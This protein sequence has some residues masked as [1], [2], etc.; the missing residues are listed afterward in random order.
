[1]KP[2]SLLCLACILA[3]CRIHAQVNVPAR[4]SLNPAVSPPQVKLSW[5]SIPGKTYEVWTTAALGE[6]GMTTN[7]PPLK[8]RSTITELT[9]LA[10]LPQ[11]FYRIREQAVPPGN[12]GA[13]TATTVAELEK[14][15][16]LTFTPAQRT[17]LAGYLTDQRATFEAMRKTRLLNSDPPSLVFNPI[18]AGFVLETTQHP[19]SWS[20]PRNTAVPSNRRELAF[21]SVRDLGE[22]IRTRQITSTEL[23]QLFLER[24]KRYDS[25]LHCVINLTAE[26]A[27]EQAARADEELAAGKYRGPLHGI[28]Y[29]IKDL[30]SARK[31][32][33]TWGAAP[34]KD[35]VIDEDATVVKRLEL[36]GAVLIA[37]LSTGELA[38]NDVWFGGMTRNPWNPTQGSSGSS[39]G[40]ASATAAGLVAFSIGSETLGS[41]VSP[42]T[43]CR[44]TGLRP[45]FGR[46]SRA[47]AM[48]LSWSMDKV[49]PICR[50]VEDCALVLEAIRGAD[51]ID[52]A[53]INAPFNY[54]PKMEVTKLRVGYRSGFVSTTTVNRLAGIVGQPQLSK[55]VFPTTPVQALPILSAESAAVFDE[56]TRFGGDAFLQS[57]WPTT[58]RNGRTIPAVEYLQ[59]NRHRHRLIQG[60][61][62]VMK[63][64]DVFVTSE[65]DFATLEITN[66]TGQPCVVIPHGGSTSLSFIGKL[67]DEAT[68]LALAKAY[69]DA[70]AFH[71]NRPPAFVN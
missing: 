63:S 55:V 61:A 50:T 43:V 28:P 6:A 69:Q 54:E 66:L 47:G 19:I 12:T 31:Y 26:L 59:A 52:Q 42:A 30:F 18:P 62:E 36:A 46:V 53:V 32:P 17:Q 51:G 21:Y 45:T 65:A 14:M 35:Q 22:L 58:F 9:R 11:T 68:V 67:F 34:F 23:T 37:K 57:G 2:S 20:A 29:G 7:Q 4:I 8:A 49:G 48:T 15:L 71:T 56:L 5:P 64:V 33:T 13:I 40:P 60:M 70:T 38:V 16:G 39:A 3:A 44:V 25:Q 41:I 27:L 1:M 24:L 10:E